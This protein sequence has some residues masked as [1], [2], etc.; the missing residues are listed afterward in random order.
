M[1]REDGSK[2]WAFHDKP[3]Y[4]ASLPYDRVKVATGADGMWAVAEP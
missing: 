1:T 4:T 2:Q 3:L